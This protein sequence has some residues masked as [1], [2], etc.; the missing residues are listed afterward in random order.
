[1]LN[2]KMI[3]N[4]EVETLANYAS[5]VLKIAEAEVGYLEKASSASLDNKTAN[6]GSANY[7][8]Y[9][10]DMCKITGVYGTHAAW[11]HCFLFLKYPAD[12]GVQPEKPPN[13]RSA[14]A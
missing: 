11:C 5:K 1:M 12:V 14:S 8:K 6:A 4:Q 3:L 10:R 2:M 13:K 9:G 7:T